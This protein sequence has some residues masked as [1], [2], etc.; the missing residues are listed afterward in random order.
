MLAAFLDL[1]AHTEGREIQLLLKHEIGG[2]LKEAKKKDSKAWYLPK[3]ANIVRRDI[4]KV[5]NLVN[6][7]FDPECQKDAIPASLRTL[8]RMMIKGPTTKVYQADSRACL[9]VTQLVVFNSISRGRNRPES[10]ECPLPIYTALKMHG[11]TRDKSL[12]DTFYKLGMCISYDRLLSISTAVTISVSEGVVCASKLRRG[13]FT[14]AVV[15]NI[16]HNPS[17]TSAHDSFHCTAISLVQHP[18]TEEMGNERGIDIFDTTKSSTSKK[19]SQLPSIYSEVLPVAL[20]SCELRAP[21][22][23]GQLVTCNT[24]VTRSNESN[25]GEEDLLEN[26]KKLLCKEELDQRDFLSWAA[27]RTS[28]SSLLC[29]KP[30]I[31]SLLPMFVENALSLAMIVHA[32][33]VIRSAVQHVNPSQIPVLAADQPLFALA[34][35]IQWTLD[36]VYSEDQFI[37]MLGEIAQTCTYQICLHAFALSSTCSFTSASDEFVSD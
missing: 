14:T 19:I 7:S 23:T 3:A 11:A 15:D 27:Y 12:R 5:K 2:M 26:T 9:T 4:L 21:E 32:I 37:V 35:Q 20:P 22:I 10:R 17:P 29:H 25:H 6:G 34:K 13:L 36:D 30:A 24:P 28:Q 33:K 16:D 18:T 31:I 8:R 1:M